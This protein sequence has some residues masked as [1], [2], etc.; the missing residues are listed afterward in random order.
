MREFINN[1]KFTWKYAK[2][3]KYKIIKYTI[4]NL[5][6][7]IIS[8]VVP[9][10]SAKIIVALT[11]NLFYQV[12]L[13][14]IVLFIVNFLWNVVGYLGSFYTQ[15]IYRESFVR[16]QTDLGRNILKLENKIIDSKNSGVFIQRL[17]NDTS[18][19]ADIFGVLNTYLRDILTSV[20]IFFAIL[21]ILL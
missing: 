18:R 13:I 17:T 5:I 2:N 4:T 20:G 14:G 8:V 15:Y 6:D 19:I 11:S 10:L 1:L 9:I 21:C 16:I 3:E 7:V 12:V